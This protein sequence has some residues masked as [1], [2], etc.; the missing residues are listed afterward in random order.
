MSSIKKKILLLLLLTMSGSMLLAGLSLNVIIKNNYEES[1]A[2]GFSNYYE[3]VRSVFRKIHTDTQFF[4][5]E[6]AIRD[7]VKN[8]L[9]LISEYSNI[10]NYEAEIY[11]EEKK[12]IS[13]IL[14]SYA[15]ASHLFEIKVYDKNGWLTAFSRPGSVAMGIVSF[16]QGKPVYIISHENGGDWRVANDVKSLP[17]VKKKKVIAS[18]ESYYIH[19]DNIV[20]V[21]AVSKISRKYFDGSSKNIGQLYIVNPF[22]K[23]VINTLSKGSEA[24]HNII[25]PNEAWVGDGVNEVS[26]EVLSL[27]PL[28][29]NKEENQE[30][31][32]IEN[33]DYLIQSF[34]VDLHDGRQ[35][36]LVSSLNRSVINTQ[37]GDTMSIMLVVFVISLL[38][39]LPIGLFFSRNSITSPIDKLVISAK[40]LE[41]GDYQ[42][43]E[44]NEEISSELNA[45]GEAFNSAVSKVNLR[46]SE[47]HA[48]QEE[49]EQRVNERTK[50][51]LVSNENLQTENK[52]RLEAEIKMNES[53]KM[54]KLVIDNIP[55]YVFWKDINSVYL[56]C[57]KNFSDVAGF[58]DPS[59]L[60]GKTDYDLPW[61]KSESD[62]YV[63]TDQELMSADR[64]ETGFRES[65]TTNEGNEV[66]VETNKIP[67]HDIN[68]NVFGILGTYQDVTERHN[69]ESQILAAK[70]AAEEANQ[71]K[72]DF[73][74]RMSH[75]LRT[76]MNAILGFAQLLDLDLA[77]HAGPNVTGNI[78]EILN[79]GHHLLD[80]INEVLDLARIESGKFAL[81]ITTVNFYDVLF[82]SLELTKLL[83]GSQD[84][85]IENKI[86][87]SE[88]QLVLADVMRL[89][90][91]F[92]NFISN[93][94]KYNVDGGNVTIDFSRE[95][96]HIKFCITD[97]GVGLSDKNINKLF[98]PFERL[99]MDNKGVDGTGIGL[100]I[101]KQLIESMNGQ[102]GVYSE[103]GTGSTFWFTLPLADKA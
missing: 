28:L 26:S 98:I 101:C 57:N 97:T 39:F 12:N 9:N 50:D 3:R 64:A 88:E 8:S 78:N 20:G 103:V 51:L 93:A 67:L 91:I 35:F 47:L 19:Y 56:G 18:T 5:E 72:S 46:E 43:Y 77:D 65:Q 95:E 11:D 59:E 10:E 6:L 34:A 80:L 14:L 38:I 87:E 7:Q 23:A 32:W 99:D 24:S 92:V 58:D 73:L 83:A 25:L 74:S 68:G 4:S 86:S 96:T 79:A 21:E 55:Q 44:T 53:S 31:K 30:V 54:L 100:V 52:S 102:V 94:I 40:S 66:H 84:I 36:Y 1:A 48:A 63:A 13:R 61:T 2:I 85:S 49:L 70:K 82:E 33:D 15:K 75:E 81:T 76:P 37:I 41:K 22:N 29:F 16:K 27:S 45:L 60:I 89:K 62:S 42:V 69:F 17:V 90:Q 71:A